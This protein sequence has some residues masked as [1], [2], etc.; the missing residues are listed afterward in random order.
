MGEIPTA[1]REG[2]GQAGW[3]RQQRA[4]GKMVQRRRMI[5]KRTVPVGLGRVAGVAG[6][7]EQ[8]EVR[9]TQFVDQP[10]RRRDPSAGSATPNPPASVRTAVIESPT[11][12]RWHS[13][14]WG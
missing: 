6:L 2:Q 7:G 14:W 10:G 13:P 1:Q 5:L 9:Q 11:G 3:R 12:S 8:A 4:A